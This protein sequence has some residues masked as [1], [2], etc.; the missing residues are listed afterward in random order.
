MSYSFIPNN[1]SF[2][3]AIFN[4]IFKYDFLLAFGINRIRGGI[5]YKINVPRLSKYSQQEGMR[6]CNRG[7]EVEIDNYQDRIVSL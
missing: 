4:T 5:G 2:H 7:K 6:N 3:L 1:T